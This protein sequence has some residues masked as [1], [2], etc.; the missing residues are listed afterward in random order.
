M[1]CNI[2]I[3]IL[4]TY[5]EG[6]AMRGGLS[7]HQVWWCVKLLIQLVWEILHLSGKCPGKAREFSKP[8]SV[9][10]MS[11][12]S[13]THDLEIGNIGGHFTEIYRQVIKNSVFQLSTSEPTF[14]ITKLLMDH[15]ADITLQNKH[16]KT[17]VQLCRDPRLRELMVPKD[18]M[19]E[20]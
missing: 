4:Q 10:T 6:M 12:S 1:F 7:P 8:L 18:T 17:P 13:S 3:L 9:A 5:M 2:E 16:E 11:L 20:E 14:I 15:G 19:T